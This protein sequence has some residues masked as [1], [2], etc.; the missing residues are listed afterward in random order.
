MKKIVNY[1]YFLIRFWLRKGGNIPT[2]ELIEINKQI[3][4]IEKKLLD[5]PEGKLFCKK[6]G[7]VSQWYKSNKS[8]PIYIKKSERE[9]AE[10]LAQRTYLT[11]VLRRLR[12]EKRLLE[13]FENVQA[14]CYEEKS[15]FFKDKNG[16][17]E[18]LQTCVQ[19]EE[20]DFYNWASAEFAGNSYKEEQRILETLD[21]HFVRSKSESMIADALFEKSIPYRYEAPLTIAN[22]VIYPDFTVINPK[23]GKKFVWEHFGMMDIYKYRDSAITKISNYIQD[24][25]IP[26]INFI[27]TFETQDVPLTS[28]HIQAEIIQ[29]LL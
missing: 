4:E 6:N 27:M 2:L 22:R 28:A 1:S 17:G 7:N 14:S 13:E 10:G 16:F 24:G 3:E 12:Q 20:Q 19:P 18:L 15:K 11:A 21:G 5:L 23:N 8:A 25:Y 26:G 29:H 9:Y